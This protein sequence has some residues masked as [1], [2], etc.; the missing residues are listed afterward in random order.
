MLEPQLDILCCPG[1]GLPLTQT[2]QVDA[3]EIAIGFERCMGF[4]A[5]QAAV[6]TELVADGGTE[7]FAAASRC[8]TAAWSKKLT[9][10]ACSI[11]G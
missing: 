8:S 7:F 6:C 2:G 10:I 1:F 5:A 3:Q 4:S 9:A 11:S